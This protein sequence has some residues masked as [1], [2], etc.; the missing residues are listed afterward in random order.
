[1]LIAGVV[2]LIIAVA[3]AFY[4]RHERS[5]ARKATATETMSCGDIA[6]LSEGVASEVG[7]GD[8]TQRCE[9]V[10]KAQAGPNGLVDAPESKLDA[11]WVRTKVV[12]KYWEMVE[13]RNDGRTTRTRQERE[14]TV[15]ENE[16][17]APFG[18]QDETGTVLIHPDGAEIDRPEQVVDRFDQGA[19]RDRDDGG[20]LST[21]LRSGQ[22]SGTLGFQHQEWI[23]RPGARLY[24]QGEVADRTG[25]L[26]FEKPRDKGDFLISTR[27]EEEIVSGAER[28]AKLALAGAA[29]AGVLG[30]VL[31]IAGAVA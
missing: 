15:S 27:S 9:A 3:A 12:H 17:T 11:V 25:A 20:F 2:L 8:F 13:T 26:V 7:G 4:A 10:G 28:N 6:A 30:V 18:L 24:V 21:L 23:I 16:S 29:V 1:V 19:G 5:T 22:D 31:L 14:E